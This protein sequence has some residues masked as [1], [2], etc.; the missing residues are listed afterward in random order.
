MRSRGDM[1]IL[2]LLCHAFTKQTASYLLDVFACLFVFT[3]RYQ[4]IFLPFVTRLTKLF[5][6]HTYCSIDIS[7]LLSCSWRAVYRSVSYTNIIIRL[8][9]STCLS[10]YNV[11]FYMFIWLS[12]TIFTLTF[13]RILVVHDLSWG[14]LTK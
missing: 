2:T 1:M 6:L 13:T 8:V 14:F 4:S 9:L 10:Q 12:F 5:N 7:L 3:F 11:N